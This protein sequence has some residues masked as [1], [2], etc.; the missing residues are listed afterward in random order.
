MAP[1][2]GFKRVIIPPLNEAAEKL[3]VRHF[4]LIRYPCGLAKLVY[5][6]A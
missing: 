6:V 2:Q 3:G 4:P 1:N 5:D